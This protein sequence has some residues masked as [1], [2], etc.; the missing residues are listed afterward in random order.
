[1]KYLVLST[2]ILTFAFNAYSQSVA[3][4]ARSERERQKAAKSSVVVIG[5]GTTSAKTVTPG[6]AASSSTSAKAGTT[7]PVDNN[8]HDEKYWRA[9]FQKARDDQRRADEK[10][11]VL[12]LRLNQLNTEMLRQSDIYN[13]ENRIGPAMT[14]TRKEIADAQAESDQAKKKIADLEQELQRSGGLP[15]WAR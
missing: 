12:N 5:S 3:D 4:I 8:G 9:A 11:K 2:L 13:R 1:M 10:V 6:A 14:Q 15:G 7:G